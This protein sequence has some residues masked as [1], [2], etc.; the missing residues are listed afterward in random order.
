MVHWVFSIEISMNVEN[1]Q[2]LQRL[3]FL[4]IH[5]IPIALNQ[6]AL[7][8]S[9]DTK[10]HEN[11]QMVQIIGFSIESVGMRLHFMPG[12]PSISIFP[13]HLVCVTRTRFKP[14]E[15]RF[16]AFSS[17]EINTQKAEN[18]NFKFSRLKDSKIDGRMR[19][20]PSDNASLRK[21]SPVERNNVPIGDAD[22]TK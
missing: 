14:M 13:A 15:N 3:S 7:K 21:N 19:T 10:I 1:K 22:I 20:R 2:K 5:W 6:K 18:Q 16:S 9:Y 12:Y 11:K 8:K 17:S 4:M